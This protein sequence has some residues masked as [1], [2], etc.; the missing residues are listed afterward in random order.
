MSVPDVTI[1]LECSLCSHTWS[2]SFGQ[3]IESIQGRPCDACNKWA[4]VL[5]IVCRMVRIGDSARGSEIY[6]ELL[7]AIAEYMDALPEPKGGDA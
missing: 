2:Q 5:Q 1:L 3:P 7:A 6:E 4:A